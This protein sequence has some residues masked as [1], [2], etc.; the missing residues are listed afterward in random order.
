MRPSAAALCL[1]LVACG[2]A[3]GGPPDD[4]RVLEVWAHAGQES[5]RTTLESQLR[6]FEDRNDSIRI[7]LVFIPEGA[8]TAQVMAS[9]VAGRLPDL[10]DLDGPMVPSFAWQGHLRPL[11]PLLGDSL[12]GVLLP[13][14]VRQGTWRES[15]YGV[16]TFDSGLAL[17]GRR[18]ALAAV[19][20]RVPSGP[21]DAWSVVEMDTLL[22]RLAAHDP[23]GAV[24]DLKLNY[25]GEWFTYAFQPA[26]RSA[27]GGLVGW[28][29]GLPRATG[30]LDSPA[31]VEALAR[32]G[33]WMRGG[34]VDP[35]LD[36]AAF[37]NGR[38]ALSWSGHWDFP[39]YREALG[40]DL[41]VLPLP[42]FG[43]G[44]RTGQG[45]W[46]W[47]VPEMSAHPE[48]AAAL[49]TFLLRPAQVLATTRANGAVP[50]TMEAAEQSP[51]FRSEGPL[52]MLL[53]E[54][55]GSWT[56]P[57]PRTPAY[58]FISSVFQDAFEA[59]RNGEDPATVLREAAT[60]IDLEIRD[61]QGY[62][63]T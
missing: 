10:I 9:A 35:N 25:E 47:A 15:L 63:P 40:D 19:G 34:L 1:G 36:D 52:R 46:V 5:E 61:N 22:A 58:P 23:D 55:E 4:E 41:L 16:G 7:D 3:G 24:L 8:Y 14:I 48:A 50:A 39:R 31:S 32:L 18:D 13:S 42:D 53:E 20:A 54:L 17:Y 28:S 57:R 11:G 43:E 49:V 21:S 37:V 56:V 62:P 51:R 2:V 38:V 29:E 60:M 26:L 6:R 59:V 12:V 27:G 33:R 30:M 45:S 44:T